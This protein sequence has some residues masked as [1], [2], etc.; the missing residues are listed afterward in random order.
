[1]ANP[2]VLSIPGFFVLMGVEWWVARRRRQQ[3]YRAADAV[4]NLQ[5]GIGSQVVGAMSLGL[6]LAIYAAVYE[7]LALTAWP[8][9]AWW[10]WV[11]AF[12]VHDFL[13]YLFHRASHEVAFL[14]AAHAVHHQSEDYNLSVALRQSWLQPFFSGLFYLPL[15]IAGVPPTMFAI[16]VAL[17]TLYQF[18][19]HTELIDRIGPL[20]RVLMTPS[21]HR[22]H[23]GTDAA[24]V[25]RNHGGLFIV[26]DKLLGTYTP[27]TTRPRYGTLAP[28]RS[29]E[30]MW[31]NAQVWVLLAQKARA[32]PR[33]RDKVA[34]WFK[35]PGWVPQ[36]V[37]LPEPASGK[38]VDPGYQ[39]Y[40]RPLSGSRAVYVTV[41]FVGIV[42]AT[43]GLLIGAPEMTSAT[44]LG[45]GAG[46]L[47]SLTAIG[48]VL[49]GRRWAPRVE[50]A[51]LAAMT[52]LGAGLWS[53]DAA[54]LA[55]MILFVGGLASAALGAWTARHTA[56]SALETER[57]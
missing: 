30:P 12:V 48:G 10:A 47:W 55:G 37:E 39:P 40:D 9:T 34:V 17:N 36:G 11:I 15:A 50:A 1:M 56:G 49:D 8:M 25:D 14:W 43:L 33:L 35:P 21:H 38:P 54:P 27:E 2:I 20:E 19:I 53:T 24:Y 51:R 29:F 23:H 46:I 45:W 4:G 6:M 16:V 3:V 22:V 7:G 28:L 31:A 26:W 5:L 13:Y 18:W 32:A 42:A 57:A 44:V 52:A 41:Q